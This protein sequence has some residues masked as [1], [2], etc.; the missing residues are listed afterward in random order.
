MKILGL[1]LLGS[2]ILA[3]LARAADRWAWRHRPVDDIAPHA[4]V[5]RTLGELHAKRHNAWRTGR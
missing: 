2:A 4:D 5:A 3:G 1:F